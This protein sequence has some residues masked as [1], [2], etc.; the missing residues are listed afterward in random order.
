MLLSNG[1]I[2]C[3]DLG[4]RSSHVHDL[5]SKEERR[6]KVLHTC[7]WRGLLHSWTSFTRSVLGQHFML[8]VSSNL[9][10]FIP[11]VSHLPTSWSEKGDK[12]L[13]EQGCNLWS[14]VLVWWELCIQHWS[15]NYCCIISLSLLTFYARC[16]L[17]FMVTLILLCFRDTDGPFFVPPEA[18]Q[19]LWNQ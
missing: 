5:Q 4:F 16:F 17:T 8:Q 9:P 2:T 6:I 3:Q 19:K 1:A 15:R 12:R 13:W 7:T 11:R 18:C 14:M 10:N